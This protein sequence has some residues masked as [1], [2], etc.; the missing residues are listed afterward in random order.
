MGKEITVFTPTYNRAYCLGRLYESL[1]KQT[2]KS[3]IWLVVDDGSTD[4]TH[5]LFKR[6]RSENII[7]IK[8]IR[9]ENQGKM[10]AH[11]KGVQ[12]CIT[13]LFVCVD[14]DDYLVD[15]AVEKC[16][17]TWNSIEGEKYSGMVA[18]KVYENGEPTKG[19]FFPLDVTETTLGN[20]YDVHGFK[21][22]TMLVYRTDLLKQHLFPNVPGEKFIPESYVYTQLDNIAPLYVL[23][24]KL[25]VCEYMSDGYS[26]NAKK[27]I[28][29]NPIGYTM[30]AEQ[31]LKYAK[32][33]KCK[34]KYA[35]Q[36]ILG[37]KLSQNTDGI[38]LTKH[39]LL[40]IISYPI[41]ELYYF[42]YYKNL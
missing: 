23:N 7:E 28:K 34:I 33:W 39:P 26:K 35:A 27:T 20:L 29:D 40:L 13:P 30:C 24:E 4:N 42:R 1:K 2:D 32:S 10:N 38:K 8:Y 41:A 19:R 14:S 3:F 36:F 5:E 21:G 37:K 25:Y 11:N 17:E 18:L 9:Q 6:W 12:E 31:N 16:I 22:D 15:N